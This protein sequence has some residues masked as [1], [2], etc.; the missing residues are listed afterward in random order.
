[1]TLINAWE[2]QS[3]RS[4]SLSGN[5][6][7]AIRN[8]RAIQEGIVSTNK[9]H[10]ITFL[11]YLED[12]LPLH[13][14]WASFPIFHA[15]ILKSVHSVTN[16]TMIQNPVRDVTIY[17]PPEANCSDCTSKSTVMTTDGLISLRNGIPW[18]TFGIDPSL[19]SGGVGKTGWTSGNN[20]SPVPGAQHE[21][22]A[23]NYL[24]RRRGRIR[25]VLKKPCLWTIICY[26]I[27][28]SIRL[29]RWD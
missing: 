4:L 25:H 19:L 17:A 2:E 8:L 22:L 24:Q 28:F 14:F 23:C 15:R 11:D 6:T 20:R 13:G 18:N 3:Q 10:G 21:G 16:M 29:I 7:I 12:N 5:L 1:M 27:I 26:T 9:D